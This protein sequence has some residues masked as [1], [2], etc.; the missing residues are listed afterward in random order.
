[1]SIGF[2]S[3]DSLNNLTDLYQRP[4]TIQAQRIP[5]T[6]DIYPDNTTWMDQSVFPHVRYVT[7]GS[8]VW[9][10]AAAPA[11][12]SLRVVGDI[13]TTAGNVIINGA[14]KQLRVHGGAATDFIGTST[15]VAGT[16][17]IANTNIAATDRIFI[18]RSGANASTT[19][20]EISYT[21]T[22]ATSFT[23]TSLIIGTPASTQTGDLSSFTYLIVRQV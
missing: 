2:V 16:V 11:F 3:S 4:V 12:T 23:V 19:L 14:G 10:N 17:T 13:T 8:G 9:A 6:N 7:V 22:A 15:L 20:G 21:I 1:M 18:Q 5:T